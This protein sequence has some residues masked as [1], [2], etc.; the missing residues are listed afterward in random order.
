MNGITNPF[1]S[2]YSSIVFDSRDWASDKNDAWIYGITVGWDWDI[3]KYDSFDDFNKR[4][5]W[6]KETW[7]RLQLLH[8]RYKTQIEQ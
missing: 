6:T 1:E 7:L 8:E 4:F 2:L 3:N 5:G